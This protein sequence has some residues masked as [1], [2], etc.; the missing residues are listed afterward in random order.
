MSSDV[1]VELSMDALTDV[2]FGVLPAEVLAGANA[3]AFA[4]VTIAS[5]FPMSTPLEEFGRGAAFDCRLL[6]LLN[7]DHVLQTWMPSYHV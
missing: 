7:C 2:M 5:E 3:N 1:D 6:T 4:G